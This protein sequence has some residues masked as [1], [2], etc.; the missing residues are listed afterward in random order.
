M[1]ILGKPQ[2]IFD[3]NNTD[4]AIGSYISKQDICKILK[5]NESD[6]VNL[7]FKTIDGLEVID[8]RKLQ[9]AWYNNDITNALLS[10]VENSKVS[11]DEL[12]LIAIIKITYPTAQIDTQVEWGRRRIDMK[13]SVNGLTKFI[14]FTGPGHFTSQY[15]P[16]NNPLKRKGE[17]Q[18]EFSEE[19]NIWPYW[20]QRCSRNVKAIFEDN[21][22]GLGV[23]WST[24]IHFGSFS[25]DN[26][27]EIIETIT[28]QFSAVDDHGYGYFY[29][30][31]T[32]GRDNPE[33][34]VIDKIL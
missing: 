29:G 9:N 13:V 19:C 17:I 25:Y 12:I 1:G 31:N 22:S 7:D 16:P 33:H 20:I 34:P 24:N 6:L 32:R 28:S 27:A 21:V 2:N 26:S 11:L 14:E 8:E 15:G 3:L 30:P 10:R 4:K 23:L 18:K 5:V